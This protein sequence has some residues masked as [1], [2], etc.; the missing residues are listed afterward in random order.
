MRVGKKFRD[1]IAGKTYDEI[2]SMPGSTRSRWYGTISQKEKEEAMRIVGVVKR[3]KMRTAWTPE[4][5]TEF[6]AAQIGEKNHNFGRF[7]KDNPNFGSTRTEETRAKQSAVWTLERRVERSIA[8]TDQAFSEEHKINLSVAWTPERKAEQSDRISGENHPNYGKVQS[9]ESNVKRSVALIG[10]VFSKETIGKKSGENHWNFKNWASRKPYCQN[11]TNE[12]R[13]RIRDLCNRVCNICGKSTF[14][15]ID[16]NGKWIGRL[17]VDH[18][19]ENKMQGCD[20]WEWRL[21]TLCHSCHSKM[22]NKQSHFLLE[23]LLLNNKRQQINF[24]FGDDI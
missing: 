15:N 21:T 24:L 9:E 3:A 10:R 12:I 16:K 17:V 7:G 23:L 2:L 20:N 5:R 6:S 4:R 11:W 22:I 19:D 8:L 1:M 14:Q 18:L 13:E